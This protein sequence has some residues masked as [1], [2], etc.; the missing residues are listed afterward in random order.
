MD[1][2]FSFQIYFTRS[3]LLHWDW[4]FPYCHFKLLHRLAGNP[5]SHPRVCPLVVDT[6][7]T[8]LVQ[9]IQLCFSVHSQENPTFLASIS[10]KFSA[11]VQIRLTVLSQCKC[12]RGLACRTANQRAAG[13]VCEKK[14]NDNNAAALMYDL[15]QF[16]NI[17]FYSLFFKK[18][19]F[20]CS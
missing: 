12:N 15:L 2:C 7:P 17:L 16:Q 11:V 20:F 1:H 19:F 13:Q 14:K 6:V 18:L 8:M 4:L 5:P 9:I 10:A 3:S